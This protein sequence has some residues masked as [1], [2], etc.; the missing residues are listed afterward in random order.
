MVE[1]EGRHT[2]DSA[3]GWKIEAERGDRT[4]CPCVAGAREKVLMEM[5]LKE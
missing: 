4:G 3:A 1:L 2:R 5:T